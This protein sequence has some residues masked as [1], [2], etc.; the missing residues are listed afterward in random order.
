[1]TSCTNNEPVVEEQNIAESPS[2]TTT[3]TQLRQQ[4]NNEGYVIPTTNPTGNIVF[5]FCF[6]FVYPLNLSYN[7]GTTV[8]VDSLEDLID[9]MINSNDQLY[10]DGIAFPFDVEV[11]NEDSD[12][13]EVVTIN[14]EEAFID[15]LDDCTFDDFDCECGDDYNPVCVEIEAPDGELFLVS[16]PN[17]CLAICDGFT[18]NDFAENCED[19]YNN[20]GGYE[21]FEFNFP[22]T[23]ITD[24][25]ETITV[26][27]QEEL[28]NAL[29]NSY[30]FDFVYP[31]DV[32]LEED[33][34]VVT[35]ET[36]EDFEDIYDDCYDYEVPECDCEDEVFDPVCVEA[37]TPIGGIQILTFNNACLAECEGF[38]ES[39]FIDCETQQGTCNDQE[40]IENLI[41][42]TW[43]SFTSLMN[44]VI[45]F[46][47][48]E[49]GTLILTENT[50]TDE[51]IDGTW[52]IIRN[53]ETGEVYIFFNLPA[54]YD[55]ISNY[56]WTVTI[57]E[58]G[59]LGLES[60]DESILFEQDCNGNNTTVITDCIDF[61][62]PI[63]IVVQGSTVIT[64][65]SD[66]ELNN[67]YNPATSNF[68]YPFNVMLNGGDV[69]TITSPNELAELLENCD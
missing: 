66:E 14:N 58:E 64:V 8:T 62:Y 53:D 11:Y 27:S 60:G 51:P 35:I 29:Y 40:I 26:N 54:P 5:D 17:E 38:D 63:S 46:E 9:I 65:N 37:E 36:S 7:N 19:D 57:C 20:T 24:N 68:V 15:L 39:D 1:M 2:I 69:V 22:L 18:P 4:F 43:F 41:E 31:F 52:E 42:C 49:D 21:C 32:T 3:L 50:N 16:Y 33:D 48:N 13:I 34:E 55:V 59:L 25:N 45:G 30:Y 12:A 6:D 44:N 67:L 23:I 47:F 56:D 28:D 61:Q 10:I